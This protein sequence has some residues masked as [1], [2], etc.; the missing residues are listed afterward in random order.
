MGDVPLKDVDYSLVRVDDRLNPNDDTHGVSGEWIG[1]VGL[2]EVGA[3]I[4]LDT[5]DALASNGTEI[6]K[7][8]LPQLLNH[9]VENG[10]KVGVQYVHD[11]WIDI[12]D[13]TDLSDL[14]KF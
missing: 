8:S 12:D 2:A 1:L 10:V 11:N 13:I 4:V 7:W 9:L 3:K 5:C 6:A 14:Y